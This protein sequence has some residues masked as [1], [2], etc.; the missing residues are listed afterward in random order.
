MNKIEN[1]PSFAYKGLIIIS[2]LAIIANSASIMIVMGGGRL[3]SV[4]G[5]GAFS[6]LPMAITYTAIM[7]G[8]IPVSKILMRF[9]IRY[10]L[11]IIQ[12]MSLVASGIIIYATI[13]ESFVL[14]LL[15]LAVMGFSLAGLHQMRFIAT[16]TVDE[17]KKSL[18]LSMIVGMPIFGALIIPPLS[19]FMYETFGDNSNMSPYLW[20][21]V[22]QFLLLSINV[23]TLLSFNIPT[24]LKK[25]KNN[26]ID[27]SILKMKGVKPSIII[28]A[29]GYGGMTFLMTATPLLM[30]KSGFS[31][32]ES[33]Q[34][35]GY[36]VL[37]MAIPSF[38]MGFIIIKLGLRSTVWMG[39]LLYI[40]VVLFN[41]YAN[42]DY[43]YLLIGLVLLG[44]GWSSLYISGSTSLT[45]ILTPEQRIKVQGVNDM[46][47]FM[48]SAIGGFLAGISLHYLGW[49]GTNI[50]L[51]IIAVIAV[52]SSTMLVHKKG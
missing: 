29:L 8:A 43:L 16:D 47:V 33:N 13:L 48:S 42:D 28:S 34:L 6:T 5:M 12:S 39:A 3:A 22:T 19:G 38:F 9:G 51:L 21:F 11:L 1:K 46:F 17:S 36:H 18:V 10:G 50:I 49:F 52:L 30:Q 35:I 25:Q 24:K 44:I 26:K 15:S 27:F 23:I 45:K 41:I 32:H 4:L 37:G 20:F 7:I 14:L 2:V 31:L 40:M